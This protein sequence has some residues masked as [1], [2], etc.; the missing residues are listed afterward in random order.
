MADRGRINGADGNPAVSGPF[1][2][3]FKPA[4]YWLED[5]PGVAEH[6]APALPEKADVVV[7]GSGYTG[8]NAA[9]QT[10]RGGRDTVIL[11]AGAPGMGCSTRNGAHISTCIKPG[12]AALTRQYGAERAH[13]IRGEGSTA[14]DWIEEFTSSEKIDCD[15]RRSG[16]FHGAH[17][18]SAYEEAAREAEKGMREE[19]TEA[20]AVPRADQRAEIG[21]DFYHGGV[22][23]PSFATLHPVKYHRGLMRRARLFPR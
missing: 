20:F 15:F 22:V 21:S 9:I 18:P 10:A 19:G 14:L 6:M 7:I 23:F 3:D 2:A 4:P 12:L 5:C 13:A 8:L 16:R 1:S 11:E 17:S